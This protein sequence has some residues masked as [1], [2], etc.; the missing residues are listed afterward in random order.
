MKFIAQEST[1]SH[2]SCLTFPSW[3]NHS[4]MDKVSCSRE[5]EQTTSTQL[6][7]KPTEEVGYMSSGIIGLCVTH[8]TVACSQ[9]LELHGSM[10]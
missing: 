10:I 4:N 3:V 2:Y 5:K 1:H 7:P 8:G 9:I 6:A